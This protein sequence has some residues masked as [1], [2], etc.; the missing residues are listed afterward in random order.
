[1]MSIATKEG[2]HPEIQ[3]LALLWEA[4]EYFGLDEAVADI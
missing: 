2:K 1:M 4:A 3:S